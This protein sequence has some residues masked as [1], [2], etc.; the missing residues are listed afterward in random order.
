MFALQRISDNIFNIVCG[1]GASTE[2]HGD[3]FVKSL[4]KCKEISLLSLF[5]VQGTTNLVDLK[6]NKIS[7]TCVNLKLRDNFNF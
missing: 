1:E 7:I 4:T 2:S 3:E 5:T 6:Q